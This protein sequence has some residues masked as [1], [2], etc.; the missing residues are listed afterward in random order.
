MKASRYLRIGIPVMVAAL[1]LVSV[2]S[3]AA[4]QHL[5]LKEFY[6][7]YLMKNGDPIELGFY[8]PNADY[9]HT[10]ANGT[11][12]E[13]SEPKDLL[14]TT[15]NIEAECPDAGYTISGLITETSLTWKGVATMKGSITVSTPGS[16]SYVLKNPKGAIEVGGSLFVEGVA[17]GKRVKG[18]SPLCAPEESEEFIAPVFRHFGWLLRSELG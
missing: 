13:N 17:T 18:S 3:A 10:V 14:G 11:V 6:T 5:V 9:C 12:I 8:T 1:A 2:S 7:E 15:T 16:C 4:T